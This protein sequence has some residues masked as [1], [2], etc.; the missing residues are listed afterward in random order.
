MARRLGNRSLVL[1]ALVRTFPA[2]TGPDSIDELL[3]AADEVLRLDGPPLTWWS[4]E[5]F[6]ARY[7]ALSQ[8]GDEAGATR[9]LEA[10]GESSRQLRISEA[11]WQYDRLCAQS[12]INAG[13]F[14]GAEARFNDLLS[15][16]EGFRQYA[17]FHYAA[18][19]NA[20]SWAR[21]GRPLLLA[22]AALGPSVDVAWQWAAAIPSYRAERVMVLALSGETAAASAELDDLARDGFRQVTRD[23]GY[24]FT[25]GRLAQAAVAL[26][27]RDVAAALYDRL[28]PYATFCA[29]NGMS[30]GIGSVAYYLGL[31]AR[32]L[33]KPAEARA[34]FE[35]AVAT[36]DR[37]GDRIHGDLARAA[38]AGI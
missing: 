27:R 30:L 6:L 13:D 34:H 29:V 35:A 7:Y 11:V 28:L 8:R 9:A 1:E 4:A 32:Y 36:N 21:T 25:L 24:L 23:I 14:E 31:L 19:M 2:L 38:L 22:G 17:A 18:Q 12:A 33:E 20:I 15:R 5:A 26:R 16:S 10:F 37:I 3:A